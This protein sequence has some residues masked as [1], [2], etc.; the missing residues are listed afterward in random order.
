MNEANP[1]AFYLLA[2]GQAQ[3]E[4]LADL[5]RM[6]DCT[7]VVADKR[8]P[9]HRAVRLPCCNQ[10]LASLNATDFVLSCPIHVCRC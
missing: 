6:A 2:N 7:L 9:V 1:A 8:L 4:R 5:E 10:L 3:G